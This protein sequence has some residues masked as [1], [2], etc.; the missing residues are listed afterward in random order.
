LLL[1]HNYDIK[2]GDFGLSNTY[3]KNKMLKTA[4]GS[5]CYAAPE[6]IAGKEYFAFKVDIWSSGIILFAMICGYLPF[7]DPQTRKLYKKMLKVNYTTP[8]Y[9]SESAKDLIRGIL[10]TDPDTRFSIEDIKQHAGLI[11]LNRRLVMGYLLD[12][13][14]L[15]LIIQY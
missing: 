11:K 8:N 9:I 12:M 3:N 10:K 15:K 4:C 5:L 2:I 13:K 6:I 7:E 14:I 1:D